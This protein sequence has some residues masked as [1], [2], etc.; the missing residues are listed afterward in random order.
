[1]ANKSWLAAQHRKVFGLTQNSLEKYTGSVFSDVVSLFNLPGSMASQLISGYLQRRGETARDILL[2]ELRKGAID[3]L[4]VANEDEAI[5]IIYRYALAARNGA[6]NRNLKLLAKAMVGLA[7]RDKLFSD[8]FNKHVLVLSQ[9]SRDQIF[10]L[11]RYYGIYQVER[12]ET[13]DRQQ[14]ATFSWQTLVK[15][16]VPDE[17]ETEQHI[18][19]I[20]AQCAALG[21]ML[22]N[23]AIGGPSYL[24]SP[25]MNEISELVK[26]HDVLNEEN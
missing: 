23:S 24:F 7:E 16:M 20:L 6:A 4:H 19:V 1:M 25:L 14:I 10:I 21:L 13:T 22:P 3:E 2:V 18:E 12:N 17:F 5:S 26:F 11:A 9:L 8:E 15:A